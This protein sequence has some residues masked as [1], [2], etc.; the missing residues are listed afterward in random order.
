MGLEPGAA[1]RRA[2]TN[3]LSYCGTPTSVKEAL[4]SFAKFLKQLLST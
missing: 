3:P 2:Q 1:D 4:P